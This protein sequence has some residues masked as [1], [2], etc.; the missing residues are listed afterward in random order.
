[1]FW[2]EGRWC[3]VFVFFVLSAFFLFVHKSQ[4]TDKKQHFKLEE[5]ELQNIKIRERGIFEMS[6][7]VVVIFYII[8]NF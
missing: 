3:F 1:M 5:M 7:E 8:V 2:K 6:I 4:V